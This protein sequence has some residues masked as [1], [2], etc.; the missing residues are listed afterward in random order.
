MASSD[1]FPRTLK[2][3][4]LSLANPAGLIYGTIAVGALLAAESTQGQTYGATVEGACV[5]LALYWLAYTYAGFVGE[6]LK[7]PQSFSLVG[8]FNALAGEITVVLGAGVPLIVVLICWAVGVPLPNGIKVAVW[9][10]AAMI[11]IYELVAGI[12]SGLTGTELIA[13]ASLGAVLGVLLIVL[14][15][16]LH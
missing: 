13:Q 9:A 1:Y 7:T 2:R 12:R 16:L 6:R 14:R 11:F 4:L 15:I 8:F 10:S 3:R 5:A